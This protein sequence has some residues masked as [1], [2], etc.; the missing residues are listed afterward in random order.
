VSPLQGAAEVP[1]P[2]TWMC[3]AMAAMVATVGLSALVAAFRYAVPVA[4]RARGAALGAAAG[5]W[6]GL[7][8]HLRCPSAAPL[9]ILLGHA[10]PIALVALLGALVAPRFV[11]P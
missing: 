3:L 6:A 7:A 2:P 8:M 10:V 9:H 5:A 11:R 1:A 4:P